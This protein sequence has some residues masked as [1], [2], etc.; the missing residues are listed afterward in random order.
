[1]KI[2]LLYLHEQYEGVLSE[3]KTFSNLVKATRIAEDYWRQADKR[4]NDVSV[5]RWDHKYDDQW[6]A[7]CT[8]DGRKRFVILE[9]EVK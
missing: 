5:L 4:G 9:L 2:Y 7:K 6:T 8:S 3:Y 1:M